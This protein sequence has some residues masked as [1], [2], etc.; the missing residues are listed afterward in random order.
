MCSHHY[1]E[2]YVISIFTFAKV[3]NKNKNPQQKTKKIF[4]I[5]KFFSKS[6]QI[7]AFLCFVFAN[8][9]IASSSFRH[10]GHHSPKSKISSLFLSL[11]SI[12]FN[13]ASDFNQKISDSQKLTNNE[14]HNKGLF[15]HGVDGFSDGRQCPC[16]CGT[17]DD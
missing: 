11:S 2:K 4:P 8:L 1:S 6:P 5:P 9:L 3:R 14:N 15:R 17:I 16:G 7:C 13:F 10:K 12:L